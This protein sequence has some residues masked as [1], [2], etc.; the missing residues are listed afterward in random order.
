MLRIGQLQLRGVAEFPCM[1]VN[2]NKNYCW[3]FKVNIDQTFTGTGTSYKEIILD[4]PLITL[5]NVEIKLITL[6]KAQEKLK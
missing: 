1:M 2:K 4:Q 3:T 5:K 6:K